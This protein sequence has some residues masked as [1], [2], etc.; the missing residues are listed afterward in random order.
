MTKD[1]FLGIVSGHDKQWTRLKG[2][3]VKSLKWEDFPW[4]VLPWP[5]SS[6]DISNA[7][8]AAYVLA[9]HFPQDKSSKARIKE[10]LLRWHPDRVAADILGKVETADSDRVKA[11][12]NAVAGALNELYKMPSGN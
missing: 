10:Y 4:P 12:V 8:V 7:S 9:P 11:G 2:P 1:Q 5:N 3:D 6:D